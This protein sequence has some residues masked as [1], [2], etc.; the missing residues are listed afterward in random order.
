[1]LAGAGS[2]KTR[3][4]ACRAAHLVNS[5][6]AE[7][8][9]IL[10]LT[11]TNKAA[12]ELKS[13][14]VAMI[15]PEGVGVTAGTF[16]ST[17]ARIMRREGLNIEID[18]HFTIVDADDR[19][20][21]IAKN[22]LQS[23]DDFTAQGNEP[24]DIIAAEVY[25]IYERRLE[26]MNGLDFNDLLIRP[27]RAFREHPDFL[28]RLQKRFRYVLVDE[29]QDTNYAQYVLVREIA[30]GHGNLCVVG[31][32]DQ[33]IYG[34]RGANLGNIL[35]FERDWPKTRV[36]RLEQNYRS[37]KPILNVAWSV[38]KH[39][40]K[41]RSKKLWT[42]KDDG[43]PVELI[44]AVSDEDEA[45]KVTGYIEE[46]HIRNNRPLNEMAILYRTNAQSL[47]FER[48][49]RSAKIGYKVVGGLRFYERKEIRDVLAY[50]RLI[51]NPADD[52]S[53]LRIINYPPRGIGKALLTDVQARARAENTSLSQAISTHIADPELSPRRRNILQKFLDLMGGF[54]NRIGELSFPDLVGEIITKT[55]LKSRL[56]TE[57]KDDPSHAESRIGNLNS[58]LMDIRRYVDLNPEGSVESF[59]EEVSL[60]TDADLVDE[61]VAGVNLLTL[62][63]AKGLE[64]KV[65][66]IVGLEDGLLPLSPR[67][68]N[69]RLEDIDEER[70]LF[71][72]GATRAMD[73]LVLSYALNRFRWGS[74]GTGLPS[75][76]LREIP[77]EMLKV[78]GDFGYTMKHGS[79]FPKRKSRASLEIPHYATMPRDSKTASRIGPDELRKGLL[80]KHFKFGLGVIVDFRR[81]GFESRI[82][83][84]FDDAGKKTLVLK[85]AKLE[86]VK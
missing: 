52:V 37:T 76:F 59:L 78:K 32:D 46:E 15:G 45:L 8:Y 80:V 58:L 7:P 5:G 22:A 33:A 10:A 74:P 24:L 38:I 63:S 48:A 47:A 11:F 77:P 65:V 68:N 21:L 81:N 23:P 14:I 83:V 85:Y 20:R 3:V 67:D 9:Q 17:F 30:R 66:F 41:R 69:T 72:V 54:R 27:I 79:G 75:R 49:L 13:R 86:V 36:I 25:R 62:H 53:L 18:P 40:M 29:F 34:W 6:L 1:M 4:L 61:S 60:V 56:E 31:D 64:F 70:R 84:D 42:V 43:L 28:E 44:E 57:D 73:R 51:V 19:R 82:D 39:N 55:D 26:R 35:D 16:H 12:A 50:L 2:G 71:Y